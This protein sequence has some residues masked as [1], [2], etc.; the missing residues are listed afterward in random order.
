MLVMQIR[1]L[2]PFPP[3]PERPLPSSGRQQCYPE[4]SG[5]PPAWR[6]ALLLG[7][8]G[9]G[10]ARESITGP[11]GGHRSTLSQSFGVHG[12]QKGRG[13]GQAAAGEATPRS[14]ESGTPGPVKRIEAHTLPVGM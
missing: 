9:S 1:G 4:W 6:P 5:E 2:D 7:E 10:P 14:N 8:R 12:E 11:Q 13:E 3:V